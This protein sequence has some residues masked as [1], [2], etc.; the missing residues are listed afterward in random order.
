M[1][2]I[3]RFFVLVIAVMVA[4]LGASGSCYGQISSGQ[5][6]PAFSL[7]DLKGRTYDLSQMKERPMII[8]YF[9]DVESRPS[10][11]GL[12]SLHQIAQ[13]YKEADMTVW[14]I[15]L[16]PREKVAKFVE[17]S[18]LLFPA[19]LDIAKVSDLYQARQILPTVCIIGQGLKVLDSFQGGGKTTET[20]L[21]RVAERE[22]QRKQTKLA[23]AISDEVIKKNPQNVKANTVKGYAA[24]KEQNLKEAEEI[25]KEVSKKGAQGE[26]L[27]KEGLAAVYAQ[28]GQP[29]KAL[30][31]AKEVGQKAP[32]RAYVHVIKGDALYAQDKKREAE[33]EYQKG[34]QIG[35][36][37]V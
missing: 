27:G 1:K 8:L 16:S 29:E 15:T 11:E 14:A 2:M 10:Q 33:A 31:L 20:M 30:E 34:I 21:V 19:L 4:I 12:L 13:Q 32:D 6:A 5:V 7:T 24:L 37:H 28:K 23:K 22:L 17:S 36:A 35:R 25:F 18:G 9:F 26:I 3:P